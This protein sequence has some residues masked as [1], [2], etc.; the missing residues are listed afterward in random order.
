MSSSATIAKSMYTV[1]R[2]RSLLTATAIAALL[3][4]FCGAAAAA[5]DRP[6]IVIVLADD[7]GL[8]DIGAYGS[9]I[10]TPSLDALAS[11]GI[12]LTAFH[13]APTC[14]P[15]RT[16]LLTGVDHHLAGAGINAAGLVR[17]PILQ[18][19]PGYEGYLN[20]DVVT[21]VSLL[22][23]SGYHTYMTGKW[24]PGNKPGHLPIDHGFEKSFVLAAGGASH[25]SDAIGTAALGASVTYYEDE[26]PVEALPDDFFSSE[27]YTDQLI[28]YIESNGDDRPYMALLSYT[29][30]HWPLQVPDDWLDRYSGVY[31]DGWHAVREAR[32]ER[33]RSLDLLPETAELPPT[34]RA[35]DSWDRLRSNRRAVEMRRMELFAAMIENMDFHIGRLMEALRE[36]STTRDTVIVFLSDNG[37]EGN[38]IDRLPDS[39]FWIT[40]TFDNRL[41][42]L[43]KQGSF[44]WQGVG[45]A[46]ASAAPFRL[47]KSY[48]T[49]GALR[50]PAIVYSMKGRLDNGRKDEVVTMR[51]IAPTL[52]ELAEVTHPGNR[53]NGRTVHAM[54]GRSALPYLQGRAD[55][56]HGDAPL[57]WEVYGSRALIKGRWKA[58][59]TFPPEGSGEWEL[60]DRIADP[61]ENR[62]LAAEYP[63]VVAE[64]DADWDD[65]AAANGVYVLDRDMGYGRYYDVIRP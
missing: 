52:L 44:V 43:G 9:E 11:E 27:F 31:D 17:L 8:S 26:T 59:L 61:T 40:S 38:S 12:Q 49:A 1:N 56:V 22:Q 35:V 5:D 16:M 57:G 23:D 30:A 36:R 14:G 60:F 65:Y 33:M 3:H 39:E 32:F 6:N 21:F 51:D 50:T 54:S 47:Y 63:E 10:K 24:D 13:A 25:F 58:I 55:D 42:N 48:T 18:G 20:D 15:S 34:N 64:L 46:H 7:V 53:Y 28:D 29:A 37:P 62:N 2:T 19:R 4:F 45:W 41:A